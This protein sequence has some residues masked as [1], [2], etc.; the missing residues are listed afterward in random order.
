MTGSLGKLEMAMKDAK[1][2]RAVWALV[3]LV[4]A[5]AA[6]ILSDVQDRRPLSS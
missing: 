6:A 2:R 5:R 3:A 1:E 4:S